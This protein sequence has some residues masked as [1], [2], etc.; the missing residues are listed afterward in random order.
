M[1]KKLRKFTMNNKANIYGII[2]A[3]G[4]GTRLWPASSEKTPKQFL[5]LTGEKSL[6]RLT[7]D[8]LQ[9]FIPKENLITITN[10][11]HV[12]EVKSQLGASHVAIGE[13]L[14]RNTAPAIAL[15]AKY[16]E[17]NYNG[18]PVIMVSPSDHL[19]KNKDAFIKAVEEGYKKAEEG[20]IV[21]FGIKPTRP[22]TGYGYVNATSKTFKEKPDFETALKYLQYGDYYWNGGIFMFKLSTILGEMKKL[23]PE[24]LANIDKYDK[25]PSISIDY[26]IM[27][28]TDKL[29]VVPMD[30]GWS[31]LGSWDA[32]YDVME[33]DKEKNAVKGDAIVLKSQ[34][35]LVYSGSRK[36]A[37]I[38]VKDIIIVETE[39]AVL[40]C[41]RENSQDVKQI[42]EQIKSNNI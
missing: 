1:K 5:D 4:G 42:V 21:L 10:E 18:D 17:E 41:H 24:I 35:T 28:K 3:G 22:E 37:A 27:E 40:V 36:V 12:S 38:G 11:K 8:R 33:K 20:Y 39:D 13:P 2:L 14:G 26:A 34:N 6:L 30:C 32:V 25:L 7:F 29:L 31:D 9:K 23:T 15:G 19:I 16:I